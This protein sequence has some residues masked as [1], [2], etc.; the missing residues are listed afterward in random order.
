MKNGKPSNLFPLLK[1]VKHPF[2]DEQK[3][4]EF[5]F[6]NAQYRRMNGKEVWD[7][8]GSSNLNELHAHTSSHIFR[9]TKD[10]CMS[11]ELHP[12]K[13][14][15]MKVSVASAIASNHLLNSTLFSHI[16]VPVSSRQELRYIQA[17]KELA[18]AFNA[19]QAARGEFGSDANDVNILEPFNKLRQASSFAKIE[20]AVGLAKDLLEEE[21]SIV[22]CKCVKDYHK[23]A[24]MHLSRRCSM[25][26]SHQFCSSCK[27]NQTEARRPILG[28][29]T[30]NRRSC[31]AQATT[32]GG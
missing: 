19:M 4:Y 29:S 24:S 13:R 28:W 12:K 5:F 17:L 22:I 8:S 7:A 20:A 26:I 27:R 1:A 9:K 16:Q 23:C 6:C 30:A 31:C 32:D 10:E 21:G 3:K 25:H 11:D 15:Y 2:G 18:N 14:E